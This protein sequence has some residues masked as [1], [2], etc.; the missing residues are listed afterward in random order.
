MAFWF[1]MSFCRWCC[2]CLNIDDPQLTGRELARRIRRSV[3]RPAAGAA[4]DAECPVSA[5]TAEPAAVVQLEDQAH[6]TGGLL[7]NDG[8]EADAENAETSPLLSAV[9]IRPE[10]SDYGMSPSKCLPKSNTF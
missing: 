8:Q 6:S 2:P 10:L 9:G 5:V 7:E 1:L 3:A 4:A